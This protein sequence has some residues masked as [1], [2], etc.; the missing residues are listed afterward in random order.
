M[1]TPRISQGYD[2][3]GIG[4]NERENALAIGEAILVAEDC[5]VCHARAG[6]EAVDR[7]VL[8]DLRTNYTVEELTEYLAAPQQPMPP[9]EAD[10]ENRRALAIF[11]LESF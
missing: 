7:F 9:Y 2:P 10:R 3:A 6:E 4:P 5:M 8:S 11:L 1:P